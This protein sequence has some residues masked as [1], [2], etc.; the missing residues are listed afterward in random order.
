MQSN[1]EANN[2]VVDAR[3]AKHT[4]PLVSRKISRNAYSVQFELEKLRQH[5]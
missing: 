1:E 2:L 4:I 3:L 5:I